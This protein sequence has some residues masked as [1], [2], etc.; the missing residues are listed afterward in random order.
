MMQQPKTTEARLIEVVDAPIEQ[1]AEL[2]ATTLTSLN[3]RIKLVNEKLRK[4][5]AFD[6]K[7]D[8]KDAG[9]L[10]Y[11]LEF[12]LLVSWRKVPSGAEVTVTVTERVNKWTGQECQS[13]CEEVMDA[14][15]DEARLSKEI[16]KSS[17]P[18]SQCGSARWATQ[19]DIEEAGY[20]AETPDSKRLV[21]GPG[22][23]GSLVCPT[24]ADTNMHCLLRGPTGSGKTSRFI[25][26]QEILRLETSAIVTE[27]TAGDEAPDVYS[28][29]AGWKAQAGHKIYYF[30]PD[31][32]RS[33]RFNPID[34]ATT[35]NNAQEIADLIVENT[36]LQR[37]FGGDPIWPTSERHLLT[38]LLLFAHG[39]QGHLGQIR[40][41]LRLGADGIGMMLMSSVYQEAKDEFLAFYR[42]S[43]EGFRNG[44]IAG[45]MNRLN[46]WVNPRIVALT[47]KTDF[48]VDA[49]PEEKFTF[50]LAVPAHKERLKPLVV[51]MF[52]FLL[53]L[54][55]SKKFKYGMHLTLDELMQFNRIPGFAE[56]LTIIRHRQIPV[57]IGIQSNKQPM[58]VYGREEASILMDMMGT[59]I[60][61][62]PRDY[63]T[64]RDISQALGTKTIVER[65]TTSSGHIVER[66]FGRSLMEPSEVL[67]LDTTKAIV[68]TPST[69]PI[70]LDCFNWKQFEYAT[71]IPPP[72]RRKLE[73]SEELTRV[74]RQAGQKP[75]W[76]KV[77]EAERGKRKQ[78]D[79]DVERD[80]RD[81]KWGTI[82]A[83]RKHR[84]SKEDERNDQSDTD[85]E[86][87]PF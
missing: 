12:D 41:I 38:A 22:P 81:G 10:T 70:L 60:S 24:A 6:N 25:I 85:F 44:V 76:Q 35:V 84:R 52:N 2:V 71:K 8:H 72:P 3:Y 43:T 82:R 40:Q 75:D 48:H 27:A 80:E 77:W 4:V 69:P 32:L 73:V 11:R 53:K 47:E 18:S 62:R 28:K 79:F 56:A 58:K 42:V 87:S 15:H 63:L 19:K 61:L 31:D 49:L 68:Q 21:L 20:I 1:M 23:N 30:N 13:R 5:S 55:L 14:L 78:S 74:C 26:Q 64:A 59:T 65:K 9:R 45:L 83:N 16:E 17:H 29:T 7:I 50:Y 46:L 34:L 66:E 39:E 67:T 37:H 57:L 54:T 33:V 36:S 51:L 86:P